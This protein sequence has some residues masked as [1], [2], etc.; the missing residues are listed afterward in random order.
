MY[1][2]LNGNP[3][4]QRLAFYGFR[5]G[6][7]GISSVMLNLINA[8]AAYPLQIDILLN[9]TAIP[10]LSKLAPQV[11]LIPLGLNKSL[12]GI[13]A[14]GR[15]LNEAQ[16]DVVVAVRDKANRRALL[17]RRLFG[18]AARIV[19]RVGTNNS[20][21]FNRHPALKRWRRIRRLRRAY[22]ANDLVIANSAGVR[23]DVLKLT[24]LPPDA[25][26][27]IPNTTVPPNIDQ[28]AAEPVDHPWFNDPSCPLILGVGRLMRAK[29][30]PTLIRA[31]AIVRRK[32]NCRLVILGEGNQRD[33]LQRAAQAEGLVDDFDLPGFVQNVYAYMA[34]ASLFVLSSAWE[35]L[36]NVLIEAMATGVPVVAT[37]CPSGP[38]EILAAGRY[39]PLVPVG[40]AESMA[41]RM[42]EMLTHPMEPALLNRAAAPFRADTNARQYLAALGL[43]KGSV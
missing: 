26:K 38:R 42:M 3:Y 41:N 17:A 28:L 24:G 12:P 18:N 20:A 29:D 21:R 31:T 34:R 11:H 37:D 23:E 5:Q 6:S 43:E 9:D 22:R 32:M 14:L 36:P 33:S 13:I 15:Y 35:G 8:L 2:Y 39:G 27:L 19:M 7:G 1:Q 16:P 40:D 25:V 10:E 30:F 4:S